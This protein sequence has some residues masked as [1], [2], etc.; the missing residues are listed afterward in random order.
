MSLFNEAITQRKKGI[1]FRPVCV[2][3]VWYNTGAVI[4]LSKQ[5]THR[6][7]NYMQ[8][9]TE[10]EQVKNLIRGRIYNFL[11]NV[12]FRVYLIGLIRF[13]HQNHEKKKKKGANIAGE[14]PLS[15]LFFFTNLWLYTPLSQNHAFHNT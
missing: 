3:V 8:W 5:Q 10:V 11:K 4:I 13:Q 15:D 7:L 1:V 9:A 2:S 6:V 12:T 14:N